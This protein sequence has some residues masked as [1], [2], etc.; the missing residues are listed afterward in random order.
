VISISHV[1]GASGKLILSTSPTPPPVTS[2]RLVHQPV[3]PSRVVSAAGWD[4]ER[5]AGEL[6]GQF[7]VTF[8]AVSQ[9]LKV[10]R[11]AGLVTVRQEGTRRYY[12]AN[13]T[14]IGPLAAYL[15]GLWTDQLDTLA[16][17]AETADRYGSARDGKAGN[18]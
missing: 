9:H 10:R 7:Q 17:L 3:I 14:A 5:T 11:D 13:R 18:P 6:A 15:E 8:G 2:A 16:A 1:I 12:R 4:A